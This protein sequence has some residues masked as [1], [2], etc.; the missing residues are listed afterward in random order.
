MTMLEKECHLLLGLGAH[1]AVWLGMAVCLFFQIV[2]ECHIWNQTGGI[3]WMSTD[4]IGKVIL[5]VEEVDHGVCC[6]KQ[7]FFQ[8]CLQDGTHMVH[9]QSCILVPVFSGMCAGNVVP[10]C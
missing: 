8:H 6:Q 9:L 3:S 7:H 5:H 10:I 2:M 4:M 1:P